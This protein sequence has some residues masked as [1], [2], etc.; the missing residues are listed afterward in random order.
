MW[1]LTKIKLTYKALKIS[2]ENYPF[3]LIIPTTSLFLWVVFILIYRW[4]NPESGNLAQGHAARAW[5]TRTD[6]QGCRPQSPYSVPLSQATTLQVTGEN[7]MVMMVMHALW[8]TWQ[9]SCPLELALSFN[10]ICHL[11]WCSLTGLGNSENPLPL[12]YDLLVWSESIP[13]RENQIKKPITKYQCKLKAQANC[14]TAT[15]LPVHEME[16]HRASEGW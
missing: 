9:H 15:S 7:R 3:S 5:W 16:T 12:Y 1:L 11:A 13:H 8:P 10:C 4:G 6:V 2:H 14:C